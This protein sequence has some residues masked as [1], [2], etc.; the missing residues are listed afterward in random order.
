MPRILAA[1][2]AAVI[3][4]VVF[5]SAP[6]PFSFLVG[7]SNA[8]IGDL[9]AAPLRGKE[10]N[11]IVL[12]LRDAEPV[13]ELKTI[14]K[15]LRPG[16]LAGWQ[17]ALLAWI[18]D[19]YAGHA[20]RTFRLAVPARVWADKP[21]TRKTKTQEIESVPRPPVEL[22]AEQAAALAQLAAAAGPCLLH[23]ITG[24]GKT[25]LYLRLIQ[26][27]ISAGKQA[28]LLVPEIALTPQLTGYFA[29]SIDPSCIAVLH[30]NLAE[31][32]KLAAWERI[33]AGEIKLI[34]GSRSALFA[35]ARD[36]GIIVLDEEHEWT[37]KND[38]SP[39]YHARAAA[40]KMAEFTGAKLILGSAT[41]SLESYAAAKS[42]RI[43]LVELPN[44]ANGAPLPA[45]QIVDLRN[46]GSRQTGLF[47]HALV[48]A[49]TD[50]IAKK[51]QVILLHNR[52][53][54]ATSLLCETCGHV[55]YC[56]HCDVPLTQHRGAS[57]LICHSCGYFEG[58]M[59]NCANCGSDQL[60]G[61][62]TGTEKLE[63]ELAELFPAA[64]ILRADRDTTAARG[65]HEKILADFR[66]GEADI[67][68]GTQII[69]KGLDL[70]NVTLAAVLLADAGLHVP[71]FRAGEK[72]FALLTQ[73]AGRA[74]R[75]EKTGEVIIQTFSPEHPAIQA[76]RNHDFKSFFAAALAER[77][78]FGYPPLRRM[79]KF[80]FVAKLEKTA[81]EAAQ[82]LTV[83]I[84]KLRP[85]ET[86]TAAPA[87]IARQHGLF[88]WQVLW[89]GTD[90]QGLLSELK[91]PNGCRVD[92]DPI[93][94]A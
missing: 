77:K 72:S 5:P 12:Q 9:V 27:V 3:A 26:S 28:I 32:A 38:Q 62:G 73:L 17:V 81:R 63:S 51:E 65:S 76:A 23:G 30:S 94:T 57:R 10:T 75:A 46:P 31:G 80:D 42:G 70:P 83:E 19:Y 21:L 52:R 6:Q 29:S 50:R 8:A 48:D 88:H 18:T 84:K 22:N 35:P 53:G 39:R 37:Y 4:E 71:D 25:E 61:V 74:G 7:E 16:V 47:S 1:K 78:Q 66:A 15:V 11:G 82:S 34:I 90:P 69:A 85:T 58:T 87:L 91:I 55:P 89:R 43:R 40:Q 45:V 54:F 86:A 44:R 49:I 79:I 92:V 24:S 36:L 64:R 13:K 68:V 2:L 93:Q 20:G 41:P 59:K 67:L 14:T 60:T 56:P 33:H